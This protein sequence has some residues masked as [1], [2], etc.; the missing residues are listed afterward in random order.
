MAFR[1][2]SGGNGQVAQ[3]GVGL[4]IPANISLTDT[5]T[6]VSY[7]TNSA[8]LQ[9]VLQ[10]DTDFLLSTDSSSTNTFTAKYFTIEGASVQVYVLGTAAA[11]STIEVAINLGVV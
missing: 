9:T 7:V 6:T 4:S 10:S 11:G 5:T 2:V 1:L 3:V 8:A